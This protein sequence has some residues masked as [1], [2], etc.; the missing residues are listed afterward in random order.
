MKYR[1]DCSLV[2]AGI[3]ALV[4]SGSLPAQTV[5]GSN[6]N[7]ESARPAGASPDQKT[8]AAVTRAHNNTYV[9][10]DDDILEINVWKEPDLSKTIPVRSDGKISLPLVGEVQA[11]GRTPVQLED[12]IRSRLLNFI[13]EPAV[14]VMVQKI[15]SLKFNVMG[16]VIKP[17]SFALTTNMTVVDA[18]ATAGGFKDFA[19][20]KSI[21]VLH[22][23]A[24]GSESRM[25]FNYSQFV[26]GKNPKA[27]VK[28]QP[29]D[30]VV[31][32]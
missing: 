15:N 4:A 16:E 6:S 23:N 11:A 18:I 26:K 12:D 14:T 30:T 21:Y 31:V 25:V 20:K 8:P 28:L 2:V 5:D 24:D 7:P 19:K 22:A 1:F 13:T 10:G 29:G 17:G 3:L 9:I 27:N 32:P